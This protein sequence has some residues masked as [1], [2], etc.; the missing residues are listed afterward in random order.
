[1]LGSFIA[2]EAIFCASTRS[3]PL[4]DIDHKLLLRA[5]DIDSG[6]YIGCDNDIMVLIFEISELDD[7]KKQASESQKLSIVELANRGSRIE[8]RLYQKLG[9]I[10][11]SSA[12]AGQYVHNNPRLFLAL[13]YSNINQICA[14]SA[15]VYLHVV[16]SGAHPELPEIKEGVTEALAAFQS[17]TDKKLLVNAVWAFCIS[18]CMAVEDQQD[19]FR[20][21][22]AAAKVTHSTIGTLAEAFKIIETCWEM[23]I[24]GSYSCDWLSAMDKLGRH[25][26]LR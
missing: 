7:W 2:L 22:F 6:C 5:L 8:K 26:L 24:T 21:L 10:E 17:L 19:A 12:S 11:N 1:M 25:F 16:I 13:T 18:G 9:E 20:E 15:I 4:F 23:R 3:K 14:L